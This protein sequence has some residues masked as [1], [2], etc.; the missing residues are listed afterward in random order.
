MNV[1]LPMNHTFYDALQATLTRRFSG[2]LT[3]SA[4]YS[5]SKSLS[6]FAGI[7]RFPSTSA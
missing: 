3:I 6:R 1:L 5:F 7:S 2:G 4:N